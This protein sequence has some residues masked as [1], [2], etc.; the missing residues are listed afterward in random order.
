MVLI[1]LPSILFAMSNIFAFTF[2]YGSNQIKPILVDNKYVYKFT[3]QY[4]SN[5]M[6]Y[7]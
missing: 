3:F 6:Q 4:G 1:K 5:Q 7:L 2:Q